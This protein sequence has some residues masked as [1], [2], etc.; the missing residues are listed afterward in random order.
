MLEEQQVLPGM[1]QRQDGAL[2]YCTGCAVGS[3]CVRRPSAGRL[4]GCS[5]AVASSHRLV[6]SLLGVWFALCCI[7]INLVIHS[8]C[9]RIYLLTIIGAKSQAAISLESRQQQQLT[10][11][12]LRVV[13]LV[14]ALNVATSLVHRTSDAQEHV[15]ECRLRHA[16]IGD[17]RIRLHFLTLQE[18]QERNQLTEAA[19]KHPLVGGGV[20]K[21]APAC[22]RHVR[23]ARER[24]GIDEASATLS[25]QARSR[26]HSRDDRLD[27]RGIVGA[28]GDADALALTKLYSHGWLVEKGSQ[29]VTTCIWD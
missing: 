8:Y 27:L 4:P 9:V 22:E 23:S 2:S 29:P 11:L 7:N 20:S 15:L 21:S 24:N 5:A 18:L 17:A 26:E 13:L 10:T 14:V 12:T 19:T 1:P 25:N 28:A 16:P 6:S 3:V